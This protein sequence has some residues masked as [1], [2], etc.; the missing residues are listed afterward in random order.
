MKIML[1]TDLHG[2]TWKYKMLVKEV[3]KLNPGVVI[4]AGDMLPNDNN[5]HRQKEYILNQLN[6]HF[7]AFNEAKIY[8]LC[9]P[10]NDDLKAFDGLFEE[11]CNRY[12]YVKYLAQKKVKIGDYEF[13]GF[14]LVPNF[15]FALKDRCRKDDKK[16][17]I[18]YQPGY[19]FFSTENGFE[20]ISDWK[21][22]IKTLP[23]IEE[24]LENLVKPQDMSKT[25][26]IMHAPPANLWL[27]VTLTGMKVGS[28]AIYRFIKKYQPKLT[29][30]GHIHES[31]DMTGVWKAKLGKTLCIQPGQYGHM[32][33]LVYVSI[34]LDKFQCERIRI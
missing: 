17:R 4:N 24:E 30:H 31:P 16:F 13:I 3:L 22:H 5:L 26:Y 10:G 7:K 8:Y 12:P 1:T 11:I 14:N 15:P 29:L 21:S 2:N 27:D 18:G 28:K 9:F 33:D 32:E 25:I 34:D 23:T 6:E 19:A 20:K